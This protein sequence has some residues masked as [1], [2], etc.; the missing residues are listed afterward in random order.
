MASTLVDTLPSI[1]RTLLKVDDGQHM[2]VDDLCLSVQ[3][4]S[5]TETSVEKVIEQIV[6]D[7]ENT[8]AKHRGIDPPDEDETNRIDGQLPELD[9]GQIVTTSVT[10][11][12]EEAPVSCLEQVR[13]GEAQKSE[14]N[15]LDL[16]KRNEEDKEGLLPPGVE[17][18]GNTELAK[19]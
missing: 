3:S 4:I 5:L 1:E 2:S 6:K 17:K 13:K 11:Q 12:T 19:Q 18:G 7:R 8:T 10:N 9:V 15:C 14:K 16:R